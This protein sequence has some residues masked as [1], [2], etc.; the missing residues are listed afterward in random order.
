MERQS[1]SD[2]ERTISSDRFKRKR[3]EGNTSTGFGSG[4]AGRTHL[5]FTAHI[6][7]DMEPSYKEI[8][9]QHEVHNQV[10]SS[11]TGPTE[12]VEHNFLEQLD[13][14]L[15]QAIQAQ[16]DKA[17]DQ[18]G[19]SQQQQGISL[20][21]L[22]LGLQL[23][24]SRDRKLELMKPL[25]EFTKFK[26]LSEAEFIAKYINRLQIEEKEFNGV[27]YALAVCSQAKPLN[28]EMKEKYK[29]MLSYIINYKNRSTQK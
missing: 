13:V 6:E 28:P 25:F 9:Q 19:P 2:S 22:D 20:A 1:S 11:S 14:P 4:I 17:H 27:T 29:C 16:R 15:E 10:G 12:L 5:R 8:E 7:V 21:E 18:A 26:S 3:E 24:P 23:A